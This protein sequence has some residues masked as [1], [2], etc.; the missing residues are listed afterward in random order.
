MNIL[1]FDTSTIFGSIAL[2]REGKICAE[3]TLR[4][5][6]TH[7]ERLL[8]SIDALLSKLSMRRSDIEAIAVSIGPGS[9]TGLR[10]GLATAKGLCMGLEIPLYTVSTLKSLANNCSYADVPLCAVLN[11]GRGE[12]YA[13]LF[14]EDLE[15]MS[16]PALYNAEKLSSNIT[17]KVIM[18]GLI[19]E[20]MKAV[21][22]RNNAIRFARNKDSYPKATSLIDLVIRDQMDNI[23]DMEQLAS[24]EPIYMRK[25]A[26]E[27]K[28]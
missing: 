10:I 15:N 27:E 28:I 16:Q 19:E 5:K 21:L 1:A 23:Y 25:S 13:T 17:D 12:L 4:D 3:Y 11:A 9:F 20:K 6:K 22:Q 18:V 8:P 24:V 14:N 7:S 2:A 26:A